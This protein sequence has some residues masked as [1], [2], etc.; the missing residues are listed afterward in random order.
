MHRHTHEGSTIDNRTRRA[1][2]F[3]QF[4]MWLFPCCPSSV[5]A[6]FLCA[7]F[8]LFLPVL[9]CPEGASRPEQLNCLQLPRRYIE[10]RRLI[11]NYESERLVVC[12]FRVYRGHDELPLRLTKKIDL[13]C[14]EEGNCRI[15]GEGR[16]VEIES[17]QADVAIRGFKFVGADRG[18]LVVH[19]SS[20]GIE[21]SICRCYFKR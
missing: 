9:C 19:E 13:I 17:P 18:S 21:H 3:S 2:T 6:L 1:T 14:A 15:I 4:D 16:H 12:P 5:A 20:L 11:E 8:G 7:S 10:L